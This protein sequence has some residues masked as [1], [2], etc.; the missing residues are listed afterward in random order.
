M[1]VN[2]QKSEQLQGCLEQIYQL[3]RNIADSLNLDELNSFEKNYQLTR[4]TSEQTET[5]KKHQES[6]ACKSQELEKKDQTIG[7]LQKELE[8]LTAELGNTS[9]LNN[10]LTVLTDKNKHIQQE[11][12]ACYIGIFVLLVLLVISIV[13]AILS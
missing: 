9:D 3:W 11:L 5:I 6:I 7:E 13:F 1:R 2:N 12:E 10:Q 8:H 4:L